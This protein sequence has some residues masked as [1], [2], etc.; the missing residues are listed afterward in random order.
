M[1]ARRIGGLAG[2][3]SSS[4]AGAA[5]DAG[6]TEPETVL[7]EPANWPDA[8]EFEER[9]MAVDRPKAGFNVPVSS[10][11]L[12]ER[13]LRDENFFHPHSVRRTWREHLKHESW[14]IR[15]WNVLMF[16]AWPSRRRRERGLLTWTG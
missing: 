12:D 14:G 8:S 7:N 9:L 3:F 10:W 2:S 11:L 15:L 1:P 16:Q 5:L 4:L 6:A 13:R